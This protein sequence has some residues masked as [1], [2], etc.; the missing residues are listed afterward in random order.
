MGHIF[1]ECIWPI[2]FGV[3]QILANGV[4]QILANV[5]GTV[6]LVWD[7]YFSSSWHIRSGVG[8]ILVK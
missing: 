5:V 6:G 4:R 7:K 8:Q 1:V 2:R 3:E